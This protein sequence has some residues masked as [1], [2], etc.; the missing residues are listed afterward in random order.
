MQVICKQVKATYLF[1]EKESFCTLNRKHAVHHSPSA[2]YITSTLFTRVPLDTA[3][4]RKFPPA[5]CLVYN[6]QFCDYSVCDLITTFTYWFVCLITYNGPT[7]GE[8]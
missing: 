5:P 6:F 1:S 4:R 7:T 3:V 8:P 2:H